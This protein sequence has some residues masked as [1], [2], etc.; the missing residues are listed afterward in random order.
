M[1][2]RRGGL[3]PPRTLL[4]VLILP[5]FCVGGA[6]VRVKPWDVLFPP[7]SKVGRTKIEPLPKFVEHMW[8]FLEVGEGG[9]RI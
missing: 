2:L 6:L 4:K 3:R 7:S 1:W 8:M 5:G 9:V